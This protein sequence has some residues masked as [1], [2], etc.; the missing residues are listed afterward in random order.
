MTGYHVYNEI[1]VS[2]AVFITRKGVPGMELQLRITC[3]AGNKSLTEKKRDEGK[4]IVETNF[5]L[6]KKLWPKVLPLSQSFTSWSAAH[7]LRT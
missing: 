2:F 6:E 1:P 7:Q 4:D 3:L 5:L